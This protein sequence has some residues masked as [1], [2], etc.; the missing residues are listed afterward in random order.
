MVITPFAT[1]TPVDM[2]LLYR[3]HCFSLSRK[4]NFAGWRYVVTRCGPL[5]IYS[6]C[7]A[8]NAPDKLHDLIS[9]CV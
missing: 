7:L 6:A 4:C 2:S 1:Y 8:F 5:G 9:S 3:F